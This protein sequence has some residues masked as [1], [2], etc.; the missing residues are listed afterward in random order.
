MNMSYL[1]IDLCHT[2]V[3]VCERESVISARVRVCPW[4]TYPRTR[5][6]VHTRHL[7]THGYAHTH[8][9]THAARTHAHTHTHTHTHSS[10][11][12]SSNSS[13]KSYDTRKRIMHDIFYLFSYKKK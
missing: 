4:P 8:T 2:Y 10:S 9:R 7:R 3:Y 11:S 6:R 12:S 5:A 1:I 13:T